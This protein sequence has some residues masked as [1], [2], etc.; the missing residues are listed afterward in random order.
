MNLHIQIHIFTSSEHIDAI[1]DLLELAGAQ[2]ITLQDAAKED[3]YEI[4][5]RKV[6]LWHDTKITALFDTNAAIEKIQQLITTSISSSTPI[7]FEI[8]KLENK[9]WE[10]EWLKDFKPMR[11]G[12]RLWISP[13]EQKPD[14]PSGVIVYLDPG[15][16]FGTGTHPTT[17]L[18]LEWLDGHPL[19]NKM[20]MDY[21]CGSGILSLAAIKLGAKFL[22]AV[23]HDPQ[24]LSATQENARQNAIF[25]KQL[26]IILPENVPHDLKVDLMIA[27]I[28]AQPLV[29]LAATLAA[30]VKPQGQLILS[31]ILQEQQ[32]MIE[33]AY[34]QWF[35]INAIEEKSGWLLIEGGRRS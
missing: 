15:L 24:A 33:Q 19:Q 27:N 18:C 22:W 35:D 6:V 11:F 31:G 29:D 26:E 1:C 34:S 28:L 4:D 12:R 20:V 5:L 21:G 30:L 16:A 3:I 2:A 14:D 9:L 25:S 17:Q 23:D 13:H 32:Q 8:E 7:H 10:R